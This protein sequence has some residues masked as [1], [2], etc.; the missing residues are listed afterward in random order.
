MSFVKRALDGIRARRAKRRFEEARH[1]AM[2]RA[3]NGERLPRQER[4]ALSLPDWTG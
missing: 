4:E 2:F 3:S 1:K